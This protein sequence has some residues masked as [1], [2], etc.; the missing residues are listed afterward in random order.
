MC[1]WAGVHGIEIE[2]RTETGS[3]RSAKLCAWAGMRSVG[4][5]NGCEGQ[6]NRQ[7]LCV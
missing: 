5:M 2:Q 3:A 7:S 6:R 4:W 1:E